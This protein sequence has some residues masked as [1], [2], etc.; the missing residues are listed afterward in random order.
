MSLPGFSITEILQAISKCKT[1]YDT[2]TDEYE[3]APAR[4]RDLVD[5][6]KY[7][8]DILDFYC[9]ILDSYGLSYAQASSF[10]RKLDECSAF[11][12]RYKALKQDYLRS[13]GQSTIT[14]RLRHGWEQTWQ[15][16]KYAFDNNRA[17]S[18]QAALGL[19]IQK[20]V[21]FILLFSLL[22]SLTNF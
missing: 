15:T 19:E 4:I 21:L 7:L 18:L 5:T 11:I 10:T 14:T 13:I 20:L 8:H 12:K 16:A 6:C 1:L 3:S 2:F 22:V 9:K 17:S